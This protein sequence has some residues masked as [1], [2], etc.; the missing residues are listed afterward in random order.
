MLIDTHCHLDFSDF[1]ED[2]KQVIDNALK[3]GV[4]KIINPGTD[5]E[6]SRKAVKLTKEFPGVF[7]AVGIH[8]NTQMNWNNSVISELGKMAEEKKVVAIGEIG[9]DYYRNRV[10]KQ[11]QKQVLLKQ[12]ELAEELDLPVILHSRDSIGDMLAILKDWVYDLKT[13]GKSIASAPGVLHSF[14]GSYVDALAAID[15]GLSL[16]I[17]GPVTFSKAVEL[18]DLVRKIPVKSLLVETDSPYLTPHPF[19]GKR[20][21]PARV[22]LVAKQIADLKGISFKEVARATTLNAEKLFRLDQIDK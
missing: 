7:A 18:Q 19:R 15:L 10:P 1:D 8:P 22:A 12:M 4:N 20:N 21:E 9:L 6:D 17:T 5:L 13:S 14:A 2:R 11:T 3:E 16:G